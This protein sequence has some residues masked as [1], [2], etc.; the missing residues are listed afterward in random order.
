MIYYEEK[1]TIVLFPVIPHHWLDMDNQIT[2]RNGKTR[3]GSFSLNLQSAS[4]FIDLDFHPQF[5][6]PPKHIEINFPVKIEKVRIN[7][8]DL[9]MQNKQ[10]ILDFQEDLKARFYI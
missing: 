10:L 9:V 5:H 2:I 3:F 7:D 1:D 6:N 8:T 4:E